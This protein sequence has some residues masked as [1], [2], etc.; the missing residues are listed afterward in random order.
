MK[1]LLMLLTLFTTLAQA[2]VTI[3]NPSNKASPATVFASAYKDAL[4]GAKFYQSQT[5]EDAEKVY[6]NTKDAVMV[7][8][9]SIEF[10]ALDKGLDCGLKT[11]SAIYIG[12]QY[13]SLCTLKGSEKSLL[14]KNVTLG[15]PSMYST[16]LHELDLKS[17]GLNVKLIPYGG[18]KDIIV[19]L[20]NKDISAG[21]IASSMADKNKELSCPYQTN[22]DLPN[23][24]GKSFKLK[25][26]NFRVTYVVYTNSTD[27]VVIDKLKSA[28]NN[29]DFDKFLNSTGTI[30]NW[31]VTN[32]DLADVESYVDTLFYNWSEHADD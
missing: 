15:M 9:S 2:E 10:A 30:S 17:A 20:L 4:G 31:K 18:S 25:V 19:A 26:P 1:K 8:N 12:K 3:I 23:Y 27:P 5:C 16:R 6:R 24:I 32:K 14:D 28:A 7:Y 13:M 21:Y 29:Q 11:K 22:P